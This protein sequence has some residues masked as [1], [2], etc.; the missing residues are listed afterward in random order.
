MSRN[1]T[2]L[3]CI[4]TL[5]AQIFAPIFVTLF[6]AVSPLQA[7]FG[8]HLKAGQ[9]TES[10]SFICPMGIEWKAGSEKY[11]SAVFGGDH[12]NHHEIKDNMSDMTHHNH[13]NHHDHMDHLS[14]DGHEMDKDEQKNTPEPCPIEQIL[15]IYSSD[16]VYKLISL[17]VLLFLLFF[18]I[19]KQSFKHIQ[20]FI[21]RQDLF[22]LFP[23]RQAPPSYA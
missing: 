9:E 20:L 4:L 16:V 8:E 7:F 6:F 19:K 11:I 2:A 18:I 22:R 3:F 14:H 23:Q 13:A 12:H 15:I 1:I 10:H 21:S 17:A 5:L